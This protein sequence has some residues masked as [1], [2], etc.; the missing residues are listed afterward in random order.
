LTGLPLSSIDVECLHKNPLINAFGC[1][2]Q[3]DLTNYILKYDYI[4]II[5]F[6]AL[7]LIYI[8]NR[9]SRDIPIPPMDFIFLISP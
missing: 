1:C 7:V 4:I 5:W 6:A 8:F 9:V 3:L 2:G